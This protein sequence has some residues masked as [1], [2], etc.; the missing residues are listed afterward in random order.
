MAHKVGDIGN[1]ICLP[2]RD[3]VSNADIHAAAAARAVGQDLCRTVPVLVRG[4]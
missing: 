1:C 2:P 3:R 4:F